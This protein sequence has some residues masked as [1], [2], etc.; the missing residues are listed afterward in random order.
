MTESP[1]FR[2]MSVAELRTLAETLG[3]EN[4]SQKK[5]MNLLKQ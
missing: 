2:K 5:R 1:D 3:V 4:A